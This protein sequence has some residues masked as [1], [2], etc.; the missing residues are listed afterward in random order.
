MTLVLGIDGGGTSTRALIMRADGTVIGQGQS[1][2]S[3]FDSTGVEK[4][5]QAIEIAVS[6]AKHDAKLAN[7]IIFNAAYLG[8]AGVVSE[9]DR[10]IVRDI[11]NKVNLAPQAKIGI[12]H[13]CRIALA[14][15]L[16]SK[17]GIIQII[18]TG[19]STFGINDAGEEWRS[20]DWGHL[21]SDEGSAYDLGRSALRI[22]VMSYDG[23]LNPPSPLLNTIPEALGIQHYDDLLYR[24][25]VD[26]LDKTDTAQLA[27]L[28]IDASGEGCPHATKV[29]QNS[30]SDIADC[31]RA[32]REKLELPDN[33]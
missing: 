31:I 32:I 14:G 33:V 20:G 7:D 27:K 12:H 5:S 3:N 19:S 2:A 23:R 1:S 21:F 28:L 4:A 15:A 26:G 10:Q 16:D 29:I 8:I 30:A 18:G 24:V 13:D 11:A 17:P 6:Q 22:A 9:H 25:Y